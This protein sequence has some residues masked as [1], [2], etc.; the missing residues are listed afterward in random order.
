MAVHVLLAS[1]TLCLLTLIVLWGTG[2]RPLIVHSGSMAPSI[3]VGDLAITKLVRPAS[4]AVGE[5]ITFRDPS[6]SQTLVTHRVVRRDLTG[7]RYFFTTR[8]D[9]NHAIER[10]SVE[11]DGT[12]GRLVL[13]V[14]NIGYGLWWVTAPHIRITLV[15]G[16]ILILAGVAVRRIWFR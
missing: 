2:F 9:V 14:P 16:A 1:I 10:W 12:V 13:R 6:R 11:A 8:G 7:A 3:E 15:G 5:V 4:V